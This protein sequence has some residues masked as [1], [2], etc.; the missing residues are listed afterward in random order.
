MD[1]LHL[2]YLVGT[3]IDRYL[4]IVISFCLHGHSADHAEQKSYNYKL[5][6]LYFTVHYH[7]IFSEMPIPYT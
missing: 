5:I 4:K 7:S 2:V 6:Y 3:Y 1:V